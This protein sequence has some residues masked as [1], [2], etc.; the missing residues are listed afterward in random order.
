MITKLI[1]WLFAPRAS[2]GYDEHEEDAWDELAKRG[3][4]MQRVKFNTDKPGLSSY[5]ML[6]NNIPCSEW[7]HNLTE[8]ESRIARRV[9]AVDELARVRRIE[10]MK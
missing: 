5:R 8:Q 10:V 9:W 3:Y 6:D 7:M 2:L 1:Q 4:T